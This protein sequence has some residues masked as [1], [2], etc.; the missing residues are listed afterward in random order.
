[1]FS[2]PVTYFKNFLTNFN[3]NFNYKLNHGYEGY[4]IDTH[5]FLS[6]L[7]EKFNK[8]VS[9]PIGFGAISIFGLFLYFCFANEFI[10]KIISLFIP[11]LCV[12]YTLKYPKDNQIRDLKSI[13]MYFIIYGHVELFSSIFNIIGINIFHLKV[14][15][16]IYNIYNIHYKTSSITYLYD[17]V[18]YYDTMFVNSSLNILHHIYIR[19]NQEIRAIPTINKIK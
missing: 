2:R 6:N 16:I 15:S 13:A 18:I 19:I 5:M 4:K 10:Y 11:S 9:D 7:L 8:I 12:Y 14:L 17:T 1:M 3:Y